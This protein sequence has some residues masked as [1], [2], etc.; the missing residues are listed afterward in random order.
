VV[1]SINDA[2]AYA[3]TNNESELFII[4][5]GNVYKQAIK[6]VDK[7]YLTR[8]KT[9]TNADIFFPKIDQKLWNVVRSDECIQDK[10]D[11]FPS[12]FEILVR[13]KLNFD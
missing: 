4:G 8:I 11:E 10:E 1:H 3:D 9:A 5:G 12:T 13:S 6:K 7:I 2:I